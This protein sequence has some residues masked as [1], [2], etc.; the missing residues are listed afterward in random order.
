MEIFNFLPRRNGARCAAGMLLGCLLLVRPPLAA[1]E[2]TIDG[3]E[4]EL[5]ENVL[6]Y[7]DLDQ[8][9]CTAATWRINQRYQNAPRQIRSALE[10][11]GYYRAEISSTLEFGESCW[12]AA[13]RIEPGE[14]VRIRTLDLQLSAEAAQDPAFVNAI[15]DAGLH[16]DA[17]LHHG[18]YEELKSRLLGH[19]AERGYVTARFSTQR[20]DVFPEQLAADVT[21][22]FESGPR[23]RFGPIELDQAVLRES[24]LLAY[25]RFGEGDL[26]D[27]RQ[28][29][30]LYIALAE[31]GYFDTVDVSPQPPDHDS[32]VVPVTVRL[33]PS[34]PRLITYG[35]GYSTD[36]GPRLRLGR[37]NRRYNDRGHQFGLNAQL[38][39]V[40][41][42]VTVNYRFPWG[43]PRTEWV[44]F[45][46]GVRHE[47]TDT[48]V[49]D[50]LQFGV[51]RVVDLPANW[52]RTQRADLR[53]EDFEVG[54]QA[55][56]SRLLMPGM[57]WLRLRADNTLRPRQGSRLDFE[58]RAA[59]ADLGSD[60]SFVQ[61]VARGKWVWSLPSRARVLV[62]GH[63]GLTWQ[64]SFEALPPS[65]RFFAGGDTSVR[66]YRYEALGPTNEQG[67]IIGGSGILTGSVEY[68]HPLRGPWS[69][70]TFIDSG[71][72]FRGSS[73]R[74]KTGAGLGLRWQS[75]LGPVRIDVAKPFAEP[76]RDYRL[77]VTLG[78]D[79]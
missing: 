44:S 60:T 54:D 52:T 38:S 11:Y 32:L 41:S 17:A 18:R 76:D 51:R 58:I 34:R 47:D 39:P 69:F 37:D 72:A 40:I 56:R 61:A 6:L 4:G 24:L 50:R 71:N 59:G 5:L 79:L 46:G 36:T 12:Q 42:D 10:A 78:P 65:V 30:S 7:I 63:A 77:H 53:F 55:S 23:Y 20:I 43:D 62:R 8:E 70:A 49:S 73:F 48:F 75:P 13:F 67:E 3:I 15:R 16:A 57:E 66:G 9:A 25:M 22:H 19:A 33:T 45:D 74:T 29:T 26:Y 68:E 14:P 27:Q 35:L 21:L 28:L 2:L 31:S 64:E 1:A